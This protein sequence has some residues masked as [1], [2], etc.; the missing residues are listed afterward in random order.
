MP[1]HNLESKTHKAIPPIANNAMALGKDVPCR[2]IF[3]SLSF[4]SSSTTSTTALDTKSALPGQIEVLDYFKNLEIL[5]YLKYYF[6]IF[7]DSW[8]ILKSWNIS[9]FCVKSWNLEI[10]KYISRI[11]KYLEILKY[12]SRILKYFKN[13]EIRVQEFW[14]TLKSW[15]ICQESWTI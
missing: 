11:L 10:L 12:I 9:R 8:N 2:H 3:L 4:L 14:T 1:A 13:L 15:N 6:K 5:K 7:Q